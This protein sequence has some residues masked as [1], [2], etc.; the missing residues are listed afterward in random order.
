[1]KNIDKEAISNIRVLCMEEITNAKSGHPGIALGASPILYTLFSKEI[2]ATHLNR[3]WINRDRFILAAGHGSSLLYTML[4]LSKYDVTMDDIKSFRKLNSRTPG[5]PEL[6]TDGVDA[7]SGP[8]GQGIPTGVGMAIASKYLGEYFNRDIK[9]ID[10]YVY[11]LCGDGDL[12]EGVTQEG[13]SLAGNLG[14]NNLIILYDSNDIQLDGPVSACNTENVRQ[15]VE[16]MNFNYILVK[17]GENTDSISD[18]I[19]IAKKSDKPTLIEIKTIIGAT[20]SKANT[21]SCHGA[22]LSAEEVEGM[23][24]ELGGERFTLS[25]NTY[26]AFED[27]IL[28]NEKLYQEYLDKLDE[29]K[30]KYPE[31]YQE[32]NSFLYGEY[33][34]TKEE[35][36]MPFDE[37]N[38]DATRV[39][40][41]KI[42]EKAQNLKMNLIG[43][44]ADLANSTYVKGIN[45]NFTKDNH[46]GRNICYGVREH[47]MGAITNGITLFGITR[48]FSG[49]FFVFSDYMKPSMRMASLMY[50]PSIFVFS[51]DSIAVGEDGPTHQPIEQ[52]TMLRS[53]PNMNVIRPSGLEETKE[54]FIIAYNSRKTPTTL[55]LSRQGIKETR[56][57]ESS[58]DNLTA[59][60]AYVLSYEN[61]NLDGVI[62][63]SGSEVKLAMDVK[64]KL[65]E[66]GIFMRVVSMPSMYLFDQMDDEYKLSVLPKDKFTI[67]LEMSEAAHMYKY[68]HNG[69][70]Y[71]I[72]SFGIS[73]KASDVI[74]Y[75]GFTTDEVT[76]TIKEYIKKDE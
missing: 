12:Q 31:L 2:K 40:L 39:S 22:P 5:H 28:K 70:V 69:I 15:K 49:G 48:G 6:D 58:L 36:D 13:L 73:G 66:E 62:L 41:R 25:E 72:E 53:I 38:S 8:L 37:N 59:K 47:A 35:L 74:D 71:N 7:A 51:H 18:A 45:G 30:E 26:K 57:Y 63:A 60:G 10:N 52:L 54:A 44:A 20:S 1:M 61:G 9:L 24:K 17:D 42:L 68:V 55:V 32:F 43:G 4:H 64:A 46:L 76:N 67:A 75:F 21:S 65:E 23:R 19:N 33:T 29:Y 27:N 11:V 14:L 3:F 50:L 16:A 34:L 56:T